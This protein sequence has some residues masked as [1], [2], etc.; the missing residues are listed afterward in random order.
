MILWQQA[1]ANFNEFFLHDL[2]CFLYTTYLHKQIYC[3]VISTILIYSKQPRK[4]I[5]VKTSKHIRSRDTLRVQLKHGNYAGACPTGKK[6]NRFELNSNLVWVPDDHRIILLFRIFSGC[7]PRI[8][9]YREVG[10][11]NLTPS[12]GKMQNSRLLYA[13]QQFFLFSDRFEAS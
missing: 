6:G 11:H 4:T 2:T 1:F 9:L 12:F 3:P 7:S 10:V 5:Y 13:I 8:L